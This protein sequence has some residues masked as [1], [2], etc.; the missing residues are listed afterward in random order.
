MHLNPMVELLR[1]ARA[2]GYAVPSFCVWGSASIAVVRRTANRL[3]APVIIMTSSFELKFFSPAEIARMAKAEE[4][5]SPAALL[6]DHGDSPELVHACIDAGY[7]SVM[8]DYSLRPFNEN[9]GALREVARSAHP[10]GITVEGELGHVGKANSSAA[11]GDASSTLTDPDAAARLVA[12]TGIDALAVSIGNAHGQYFRLPRFDFER[13]EMISKAL[14]GFPLVLH[15]GSGTPE[16]DLK[17]AIGLGISKVNVATE[18]VQAFKK[19][20]LSQW[21]TEPAHWMPVSIAEAT[22]AMV[23][24]VEK[25]IRLTGAAGKG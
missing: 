12:E 22:E 10:L 7:T 8:L 13:L 17:K 24:V 5:E 19:S 3:K 25:W 11:E 18:L 4:F 1:K 2:G 23:P 20:L 14:P 6:L 15:G 21:N 16:L 9:A